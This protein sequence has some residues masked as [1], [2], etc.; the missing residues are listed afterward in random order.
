MTTEKMWIVE[1]NMGVAYIGRDTPK[2]R[3]AIKG[4]FWNWASKSLGYPPIFTKKADAVT[5]ARKAR[6]SKT[7]K[8]SRIVQVEFY[9]GEFRKR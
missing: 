4:H 5:F 6:R 1:T 3:K 2:E 8:W 9:K 7:T